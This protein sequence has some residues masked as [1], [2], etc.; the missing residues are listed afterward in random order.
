MGTFKDAYDILKDLMALAKK[1]KNQEMVSLAMDV[2]EKMFD[3][4]E[5]IEALK[6]ENKGLKEEVETIKKPA[7]SDGDIKYTREGYF[8]LNSEKNEYPYCSACWKVN[9]KVVPLAKGTKAY[10]HYV[11]PNC[12]TDFAI[13]LRETNSKDN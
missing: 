10:W 1:L 3:L 4:K 8:T 5:E 7:I 11:C 6:D 9:N 12:K 13:D 2:Q